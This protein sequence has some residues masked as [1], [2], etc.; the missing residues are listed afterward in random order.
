MKKEKIPA[1]VIHAINFMIMKRVPL[2]TCL[3]WMLITT[4]T[5]GQEERLSL[6]PEEIP[7]S[8]ESDER[9]VISKGETTLI[10]TVQDPDI[11]VYLPN[12]RQ[13]TGQAMLICPGGGYAHLAYDWEGVNIAKWLNS[14][15]IAAIVLKYRLPASES[16]DVS[17][18]APLQDAQRAMKLIRHHAEKW[19]I[20]R[21]KV[22]VIGF[23]AGGHLA[24]TLGTQYD[25]QVLQ[26]RDS[27][28]L[29]SARPD[30]MALIYPVI[31][32]KQEFTNQGSR[33]RLLG[34]NPEEKLVTQF[35]GE[36]Q[37]GMNTPPAFLLH[38]SDD[39]VV[40]VENSLLFYEA[41][42]KNN[43][44]SELHV[45]PYGGHGFSLAVGIGYLGTWPDRLHDWLIRLN[46]IDRF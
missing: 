29:L 2:M 20:E 17:H 42:R 35:S 31:T 44:Y 24:S 19:N 21:D 3:V 41:L 8:L 23:S 18:D 13:A 32:M 9:E 26:P 15:G 39:T 16:V 38:A 30:F 46:E 36:T 40:S 43:I 34:E 10:T 1:T 25:R 11:A 14:K 37:V 22:G 28:D 7:N 27:I 45:Y 4:Q 6:W 5:S 33:D 12:K